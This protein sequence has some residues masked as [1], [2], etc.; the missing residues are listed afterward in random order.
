V[1]H[2]GA[3]RAIPAVDARCEEREDA[4]NYV[5]RLEAMGDKLDAVT[6]EMEREAKAEVVLPIA[7]LEK[8]KPASR[9]QSAPAPRR[10]RS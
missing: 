5:T 8:A 4:R 6:H 10:I 1:G 2:A 3:A 7:L 9:T